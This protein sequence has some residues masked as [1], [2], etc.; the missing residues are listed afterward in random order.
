MRLSQKRC[1]VCDKGAPAIANEEM[2]ELLQELPDWKIE[3]VEGVPV[4]ERT[5]TLQDFASAL[6]FVQ[7]VGIEAEKENHHPE[8]LLAWGKVRVRWWT[9]KIRD[10]HLNDFVMASKTQILWERYLSLEIKRSL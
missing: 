3:R 8:I 10:L 6:V 1:V 2:E 7:L 9:H 4:L 5:F